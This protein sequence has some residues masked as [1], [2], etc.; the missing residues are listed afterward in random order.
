MN[1]MFH[2]TR[3]VIL[4]IDLY[5]LK[6]VETTNQKHI[7]LLMVPR[8]NNEYGKPATTKVGDGLGIPAKKTIQRRCG[9]W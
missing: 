7:F 6:M 8:M 2:H 1:F 5:F 4:P 9:G 3:D